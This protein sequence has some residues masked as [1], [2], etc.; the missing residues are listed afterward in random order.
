MCGRYTLYADLSTLQARFQF[1]ASEAS[2]QP[3][4]NIAPTQQVLTVTEDWEERRARTMR[5]GLVPSWAKDTSGAARMI[6][7]RGENAAKRPAFRAAFKRRRCLVLADGFYEWKRV[8]KS[9]EPMH[10]SLASGEPFAFAGLWETWDSPSGDV[11]RSCTIITTEP[12]DLVAEVHDRM[13]V[14]LPGEAE[15]LWLDHRIEDG[16]RLT[17]LLVPYPAEAM[18]VHAVSSLV[19]SVKNDVAE[20]AVPLATARTPSQPP[21]V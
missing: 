13:P 5:W 4:Y 15:S 2:H 11:L 10:F 14:I 8:G 3:R 16:D 17:A 7:A 18:R 9:R 19:N 21:L 1:D 20:C 6:N 12:N